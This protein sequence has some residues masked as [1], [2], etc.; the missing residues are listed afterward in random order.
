MEIFL[1]TRAVRQLRLATADAIEEGDI[2]ALKDDIVDTFPEEKLEGLEE[3]LGTLDFEDVLGELLEEWSGDDV[4]ELFDLL[5]SQLGDYGVDLRFQSDSDNDD[6]DE[7]L[8]E[9]DEPGLGEDDFEL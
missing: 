8:D 6:D 5:E 9:Y 7:D 2:E 1:D 4:D 3:L